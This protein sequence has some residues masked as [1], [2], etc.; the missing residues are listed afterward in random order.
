ML[1]VLSQAVLEKVFVGQSRDSLNAVDEGLVMSVL[2][3]VNMWFMWLS[4]VLK[5]QIQSKLAFTVLM[6]SQYNM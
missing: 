5:L 3:S 6:A 1:V 4:I 2:C